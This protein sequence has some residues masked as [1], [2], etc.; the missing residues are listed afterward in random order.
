MASLALAWASLGGQLA[1]WYSLMRPVTAWWRSTRG[2]GKRMMVGSSL[3][4][5]WWR[6][7]W[8]RWLALTRK[9]LRQVRVC[10][11]VVRC[12]GHGV[13]PVAVEAMPVQVDSFECLHLLVGDLDATLVGVGVERRPDG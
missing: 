4:A 11:V 8:G 12:G 5:S 6:P 1:L 9:L 2:G 3:G 13:V 7:W 10:R